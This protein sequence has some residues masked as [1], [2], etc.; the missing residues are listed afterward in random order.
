MKILYVGLKF[1]YGKQEEGYSYEW[2]NIEAGFRDCQSKGLFDVVY[3]HPDEL[4]KLSAAQFAVQEKVDAV[5]HVAFNESLD[6]PLDCAEHC[7]QNGIP[8]IQFDCDTSWRFQNWI[9][10]RKNRV[11]HFITT[12]PGTLQ[13]YKQ[14]GMKAIL[15]QWGGSPLYRPDWNVNKEY[16]VSFIGQKHGIRPQIMEHLYAE[17]IKVDLFGNY[18]DGYPNWHGYLT[19]FE[20]MLSVFQRSKICLNLS[21]PWHVG[22][23]PQIKGRHFEIPQCGG[24]QLSTPAD[25]LEMYFAEGKE[26]ILA[27]SVTE[28]ADKI[29]FYLCADA[30]R[31][32]IAKAGYERMQKEHQWSHRLSAIFEELKQI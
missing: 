29:R 7:I 25:G 32:D 27:R 23:M 22:T 24:F 28:L 5:F 16:D 20:D 3:W 2:N 4:N 9:L 15:S 1:N 30:Q 13:W 6:L 12:H 10:P 31:E 8:V 17:G 26:I 21:N 19:K 14:Y 18:W 11:T